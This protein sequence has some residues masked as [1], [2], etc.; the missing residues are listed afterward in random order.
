MQVDLDDEG[1]QAAGLP[2][3]Q[4]AVFQGRRLRLTAIGLGAL[5]AMGLVSGFFVGLFAPQSLWP[6]LLFNQSA[7]LLVLVAGLQSAWWVTQWR[8]CAMSPLA[9]LVAASE[10]TEAPLGWYSRLRERISQQWMNVLRQIGAP[11][12]WLGGWA[13]L[14]LL[15]VEQAWNLDLAPAALGLS[16]TVGAALALLL[17]FGLLVLERELTQE[18]SAQWPEAGALAQLTRVAIISLIL[19]ALCLLFGNETSVWPVRLAVLIGLLPGLVAFEL[20]LRAVLSLFSPRRDRLEPALLARSFVADLLR[21]P[22]QPLLALQH[23]LH[24]R[25][26]IDLRQIWAFTYMRRA[27]LPVLGVVAIVGWSLTGVHEI[28]LQGRGSTSVSANPWRC[29]AL[30]Y[31]QVYPGRWAG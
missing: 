20:L 11:T 18:G 27:F 30:D 3:F 26:G 4:Q 13:L 8:V 25:F 17:A 31:M 2:R 22:P 10:E 6:A 19:G 21:W 29:S 5:V 28:P 23:E 24:N 15:S 12:L 14:A 9:P 1:A 16:A 7:A